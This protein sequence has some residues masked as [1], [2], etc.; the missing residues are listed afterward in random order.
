MPPPSLADLGSLGLCW[1]VQGKCQPRRPWAREAG[2]PPLPVLNA[3]GLEVLVV[4]CPWQTRVVIHST[5]PLS[6]GLALASPCDPVAGGP[7]RRPCLR[8]GWECGLGSRVT[9]V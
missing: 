3:D 4:P 2:G 1:D 8:L 9:W 5:L 7:D 6:P